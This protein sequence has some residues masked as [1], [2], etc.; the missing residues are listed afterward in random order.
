MANA[1]KQILNVL[2]WNAN[3]LSKNIHELYQLLE[4]LHTHVCCISETYLKPQTKIP[5]HPDFVIHR[6]D[7]TDRPKG[8]VAIIIRRNIKHT[9][10]PHHNTTLCEAISA[11][12]SLNNNSKII[13]TSVYMPGGT[14]STPISTNFVNDIRKLTSSTKSYFVCGDL[15]ARHRFWNCSR[16]NQAGNILYQEYCDSNFLINFPQT[17]TRIPFDTR[18]NPSTIDLV[19]TNGLHATSMSKCHV[20]SS[21]HNAVSFTIFLDSIIEKN[22]ERLS[23]DYRQANWDKYKGIIHYHISTNAL[24]LAN[25][26]SIAQIEEHIDRFI[27]LIEHA[28]DRSVPLTFHHRYKL[29][30][31]D[32]LKASIKIKNSLRKLWQRSRNTLIKPIINQMEKDIKKA[33]NSIR[34][35]NWQHKLS[36]IKPSNQSVW[37]TARMLKN[38][39]RQI[40]TLKCDTKTFITSQEKANAIAEQFSKNHQNPLHNAHDQF[41]LDVDDEIENYL[42]DPT[43]NFECPEYAEEEE[44]ASIIKNLKNKK[45]PGTDKINNTLI[46]KL[47]SRGVLYLMFIVN[48]C[49]KL[50]YFP[51]RWKEAKISPILKHS[52]D[53]SSPLSYRPISLLCSF[54]KIFERVI[55]NRINS[56]LDEHNIIPNEQHGFKKKF[57]TTHQLFKLIKRAKRKLRQK[58]STGIV[59]L[60]V[61]KAF[62]RVW[63]NGLLF[64]MKILNF[65]PYLI[66]MTHNFLKNRKFFVEIN[67]SRSPSYDIP[68]GVPQGAVLSPTLYNIFTH[69]IPKYTRTTL[70]LFADDTAFYCSSPYAKTITES[71]K[72]HA[73]KIQSYMNKWKINLNTAKTQALFITRRRKKELPG[74]KIKIFSSVVKWQPECKYLG[75]ILEKQMTF[76]KH[77][78][79]V[80][81]RANVAVRTL[82]PLI[83][84]RSKLH[85]KNKLMIYKLAIR[86]IFTYASPAFIDIAACHIQRLQRFQN[87]ILRMVLNKSRFERTEL[88]HKEADVPLVSDYLDKLTTKF[89]SSQN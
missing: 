50:S 75:F 5:S 67:N 9:I 62:D 7:R 25:I 58:C 73:Q 39:N 89:M 53:S 52:K 69:D 61:E 32:W 29:C 3:S 42:S 30:I 28:R 44:I 19:L 60:D 20:M 35:D 54:S 6:L 10:L 51:D 47:P 36:T 8:G 23:F 37:T 66:K 72:N 27:K 83:S 26:T 4:T 11:E 78:N 63:H 68:F 80:I 49:L 2:H 77:I 55:L 79:Y 74:K 64:K 38:N 14:R 21:D 12:I 84:R 87:K 18:S 65:P 24:N 59:M 15:N 34:N 76:R 16:A 22:S 46:K 85:T 71:L 33:I 56:F 43:I 41:T 86:P 82:Y 40:P 70:A 17:H 31:P 57:S 88:I 45:S 48:A 13:I 81:E 1:N